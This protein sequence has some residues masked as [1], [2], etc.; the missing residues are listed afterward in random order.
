M[1]VCSGWLYVQACLP[2]NQTMREVKRSAIVGYSAAQI[3][4][5][6]NDID[7]YP[8]FLPWCTHA[9]VESASAVEVVATLGVKRGPL[10]TEF[11]TRNALVPD[12]SV[13]MSLAKG[14]FNELEGLWTLTPIDVAGC[15]VS[16]QMR[17]AFRITAMSALLEPV[18]EQMAASLVDAFVS[19]AREVYRQ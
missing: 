5:L 19:R 6:I 7:A 9:R 15:R 8:A 18:F 12:R 3:Y 2:D 13:Q 17:F 4:A 16:L 1:P 14:P 10:N 11:T